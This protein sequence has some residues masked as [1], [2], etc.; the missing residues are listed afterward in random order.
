MSARYHHHLYVHK[1]VLTLLAAI[2]VHVVLDMNWIVMENLAMVSICL[3][4]IENLVILDGWVQ[5]LQAW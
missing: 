4:L 3:G 2:G 5:E 1:T